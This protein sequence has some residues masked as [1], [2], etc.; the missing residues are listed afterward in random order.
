MKQIFSV[1][2]IWRA[3]REEYPQ[4]T[5]NLYDR[6][7]HV[8]TAS[9]WN[10]LHEDFIFDLKKNGLEKYGMGLGSDPSKG[11][12]VYG[13]S[14]EINDCDNYMVHFMS[15]VWKRHALTHG[16]TNAL[17]ALGMLYNINGDPRRGHAIV[18]P[19]ILEEGRLVCRALEPQ[20]NGGIFRCSEPERYSAS[21]LWG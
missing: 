17:G 15:Y 18:A 20:P 13:Q 6:N 16:V 8:L 1:G 5:I 10:S 19:F 3:A 9:A 7:R 14:F 21:S 4:A 2:E 11:G 12:E